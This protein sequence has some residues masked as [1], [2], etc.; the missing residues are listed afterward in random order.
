MRKLFL[1][2][3][4]LAAL[5]LPASA[6]PNPASMYDPTFASEGAPLDQQ[7]AAATQS[8]GEAIAVLSPSTRAKIGAIHDQAGGNDR[9]STF[10]LGVMR[11]CDERLR[12]GSGGSESAHLATLFQRGSHLIDVE[13]QFSMSG[14]K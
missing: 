12:A 14:R 10:V 3:L 7:F 9:L 8:F 6:Q 11:Y 13:F 2:V 5:G 4:A 1:T